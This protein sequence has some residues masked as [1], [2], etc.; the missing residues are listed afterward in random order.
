MDSVDC[1]LNGTCAN[2]PISK[3][4]FTLVMIGAPISLLMGLILYFVYNKISLE[5]KL[6]DYWWKIN[7]KEIEIVQARRK[8]DGTSSVGS[9]VS[10]AEKARRGTSTTSQGKADQPASEFKSMNETSMAVS[11][12]PDVCYG[13][14]N[15][16]I[17][18]SAKVALKPIG[19]LHQSRKLMIELRVVSIYVSR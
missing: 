1:Q 7:T 6:V 9:Q 3:F 17:Y 2:K 5:S 19:K 18:K 16:G 10:D 14:I 4:L 11:S 13:N 15:L 12:K 8:G